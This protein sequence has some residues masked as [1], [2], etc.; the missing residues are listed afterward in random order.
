LRSGFARPSRSRGSA[1]PVTICI[2]VRGLDRRQTEPA[3][4]ERPVTIQVQSVTLE[5]DTSDSPNIT[6]PSPEFCRGG[7]L[8]LT[9]RGV[10]PSATG[11]TVTFCHWLRA[12]SVSR[13]AWFSG[14]G[15]IA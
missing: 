11:S 15:S 1:N 10:L 12:M 4:R 7:R 8:K 14:T 13:E 3:E 6:W 9:V 2:D 5:F